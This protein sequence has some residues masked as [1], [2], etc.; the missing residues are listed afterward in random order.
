MTG[1]PCN[2]E[3]L[4]NPPAPWGDPGRAETRLWQEGC[5]LWQIHMGWVP[6]VDDSDVTRAAS[7]C[8]DGPTQIRPSS[9]QTRACSK[10][11]MGRAGSNP[12]AWGSAKEINA[13]SR[14]DTEGRKPGASNCPLRDQVLATTPSAF[15][16]KSQDFLSLLN[17]TPPA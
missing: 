17:S 14:K 2:R 15:L 6:P 7:H 5:P 11:V 12:C 13:G 16:S 3:A 4:S 1:S 8:G 10:V 9:T